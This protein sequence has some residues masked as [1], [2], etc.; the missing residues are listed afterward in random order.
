MENVNKKSLVIL[1]IINVIMFVV[2]LIIGAKISIMLA[3][4]LIA[5]WG[6][7]VIG[8][9]WNIIFGV[10]DLSRYDK[11]GIFKNEII[12]L[13]YQMKSMDNRR[14]A[15][16]NSENP[17]LIKAYTEVYEQIKF[18]IE[19]AKKYIITYDYVLEPDRSVISDIVL[20]NNEMLNKLNE[21]VDSIHMLNMSVKDIDMEEM[22]DLIESLQSMIDSNKDF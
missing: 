16:L 18:N 12:A 4:V 6:I 1:N 11:T 17:Q 13:K 7:W 8:S 9:N 5:I 22:N 19:S 21:V 15:I 20:R 10:D 2:I 3:G 14:E